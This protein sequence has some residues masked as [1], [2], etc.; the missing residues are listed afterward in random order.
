MGRFGLD[1]ELL[2]CSVGFELE[3]VGTLATASPK[4]RDSG[5]EDKQLLTLRT[6]SAPEAGWSRSSR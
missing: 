5:V 2:G 3:I 6:Y 1:S 4:R